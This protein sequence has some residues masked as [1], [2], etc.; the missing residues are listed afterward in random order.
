MSLATI[1]SNRLKW[2]PPLIFLVVALC[3]IGS[4]R[5]QF[6]WDDYLLIVETFGFRGFQ[7]RHLRWMATTILGANFTPLAWLSYAF[8]YAIWGLNPVGYH[9]TNIFLHGFNAVLLYQLAVGLYKA[10]LPSRDGRSIRAGAA[11]ASLVFALHPLRVESV[12]WASERRDL[13]AGF[14][15]ISTLIFYLKA[16]AERPCGKPRLSPMV[17]SV[18]I[19]ML[20][21]LSKPTVVPLPLVLLVLDY[22]PLQRRGNK[23]LLLLEKVP[24]ALI[25]GAS[26]FMTIQAQL[27][28]ANLTSAARFPVTDRVAQAAYGFGFYLRKTLLP[29]GL[30]ALYPIP[31]HFSMIDPS[32]IASALFVLA[33]GALCCA[34]LGG[35]AALALWAYYGAMLLP[36][37][38]IL[39]NGPQLVALRY[40]YL[41]CMG[42]SLVAGCAIIKPFPLWIQ[43][44]FRSRWSIVAVALGIWLVSITVLTQRQISV[45]ENDKTVWQP[46]VMAY[47]HSVYANSNMADA[48]LH[49]HDYDAAG[50]YVDK[51]VELSADKDDPRV[52]ILQASLLSG[53]GQFV[54]ARALLERSLRFDGGPEAY[55]LLGRNALMLGKLDEAIDHYRQAAA[56]AP[57]SS[58]IQAQAGRLLAAQGRFFESIRYYQQAVRIEK[59]NPVYRAELGEARRRAAAVPRK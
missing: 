50:P 43:E 11:F 2:V 59:F 47:P 55:C 52:L 56:R 9:L 46:V 40:S 20:A 32:V 41:S 45:W 5:N 49:Q 36:V 58:A 57:R 26:S 21:A 34:G 14:F 39:Q 19:F 53:K 25:S 6:V 42:W 22:F 10:A 13:L 48:L 51:V 29:S 44:Q 23:L 30:L 8:D 28:F 54:Q 37:I 24:F 17:A 1:N 3:F 38:G 15:F 27:S 7:P 31:E 33:M 12:A 4:L 35:R 16:V 18:A